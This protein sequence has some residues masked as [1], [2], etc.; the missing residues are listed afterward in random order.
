MKIGS[1]QIVMGLEKST[2]FNPYKYRNTEIDADIDKM[3]FNNSSA[4]RALVSEFASLFN[5]S[6]GQRVV[7]FYESFNSLR[8]LLGDSWDWGF[9][10]IA[11]DDFKLKV[12]RRV[13]ETLKAFLGGELGIDVRVMEHVN[14]QGGC[15]MVES[16]IMGLSV[17]ALYGRSLIVPTGEVS[18]RFKGMPV[19]VRF[20]VEE[21]RN[22]RAVIRAK[23]ILLSTADGESIC[24]LGAVGEYIENLRDADK[25][26]VSV[27]GSG[28]DILK[29]NARL[30]EAWAWYCDN[31]SS[32]SFCIDM[33]ACDEN[34]GPVAVWFHRRDGR[35]E[36]AI[37]I[38]GCELPLGMLASSRREY[39]ID[40]AAAIDQWRLA[41]KLL[42][43]M[44]PDA[45]KA[46]INYEHIFGDHLDR[47]GKDYEGIVQ[48]DAQSAIAQFGDA[49]VEAVARF[50]EAQETWPVVLFH[51]GKERDL[52]FAGDEATSRVQLLAPLYLTEHDKASLTPTV[53]ACA[54]ID[55]DFNGDISV[56]FPTILAVEM[57]ESN[58]RYFRRMIRSSCCQGC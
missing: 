13:A 11:S 27:L 57:V 24:G 52:E 46:G 53:Y 18:R 49:L 45:I 40:V 20:D 48:E 30:F 50:K 12:G 28:Y 47:F 25:A 9:G 19:F 4:C 54:R 29:V 10:M 51:A 2:I 39:H 14:S 44:S 55:R 32:D 35:L 22:D 38:D 3:L 7:D 37:E 31:E 1:R 36:L 21:P 56:I 23:R 58:C 43:G 33:A 8:K 15:R 5:Y 42:C 17:S 41:K 6:N 34:G 16:D 26:F